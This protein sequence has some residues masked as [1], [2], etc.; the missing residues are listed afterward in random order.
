MALEIQFLSGRKLVPQPGIADALM[1]IAVKARVTPR[2]GEKAGTT[3]HRQQCR[4]TIARGE[5]LQVNKVVAVGSG[6]IVAIAIVPD[7]S[8]F[9]DI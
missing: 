7:S 4:A 5:I 8:N 9:I 2:A 3:G 1:F 6:C